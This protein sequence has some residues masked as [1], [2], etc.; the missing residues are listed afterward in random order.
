MR[1]CYIMKFHVFHHK[2]LWCLIFSYWISQIVIVLTNRK[3][4]S[5]MWQE[6][7]FKFIMTIMMP[8]HLKEETLGNNRWAIFKKDNSNMTFTSNWHLKTLPNYQGRI[9]IPNHWWSLFSMGLSLLQHLLGI[10]WRGVQQNTNS[11]H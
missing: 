2:Q 6:L 3:A 11:Q 5:Y 8:I 1:F 4:G 9:L 10:K 7:G